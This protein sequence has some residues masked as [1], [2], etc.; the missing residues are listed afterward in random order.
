[1][2]DIKKELQKIF[3]F[4]VKYH[5]AFGSWA[6][7]DVRKFIRWAW[8]FRKLFIIWDDLPNGSRRIA[9][10]GFAWRTESTS[11]ENFDYSPETTEYG[12]YIYV[13]RVIVHPDYR[14]Q[15][16]MFALLSLALVRFPMA[17]HVWWD[18]DLGPKS[19][20]FVTPIDKF[21]RRL[22]HEQEKK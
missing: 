19:R 6:N 8:Y 16:I 15:P 12:D 2:S 9:G 1:M 13:A 3:E 5:P 22:A 10:I 11:V 4:C 17:T 21:L 14:K 7:G 18:Q 20:K